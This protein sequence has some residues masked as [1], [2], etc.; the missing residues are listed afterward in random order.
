ML[1]NINVKQ[2][3]KFGEAL[4]AFLTLPMRRQWDVARVFGLTITDFV[5]PLFTWHLRLVQHVM[6]TDVT[7]AFVACVE[8]ELSGGDL[9]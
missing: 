6:D 3:E 5:G 2:R 1:P 4:Q 9:Q 7:Q 8:R